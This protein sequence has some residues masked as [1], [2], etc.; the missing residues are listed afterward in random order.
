MD[1]PTDAV[2]DRRRPGETVRVPLRIELSERALDLEK[3]ESRQLRLTLQYT[4]ARRAQGVR[5]HARGDRHREARHRLGGARAHRALRDPPGRGR[6]ALRPGDRARF[7]R[8][9]AARDRL[10]QPAA[11]DGAVRRAG[12]PGGALRA[13][14]GEPVRGAAPGPAD[15][16]HGAPA[17]R[18]A[19]AA[20]RGL[21][22]PRRA[23]RR[24]A[25]EHRASTPPSW[26]S[27]TT[28]S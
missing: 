16:R 25:P 10:R 14:P 12:G 11:R 19:A 8:G 23:L 4:L 2:V 15:A 7:P 6:G 27:S 1:F 26:T 9:R 20:H 28:S 22:R 5:E 24:A 18:D 3:T 13:G 21:R 17:P